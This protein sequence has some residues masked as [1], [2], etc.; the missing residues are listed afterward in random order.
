MRR[1]AQDPLPPPPTTTVF[2][3]FPCQES[4]AVSPGDSSAAADIEAQALVALKALHLDHL[5]LAE[6]DNLEAF[7]Q[8]GAV[9]PHP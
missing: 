3:T 4:G 9:R 8:V 1:A 7:D 2:L 5:H 6:I